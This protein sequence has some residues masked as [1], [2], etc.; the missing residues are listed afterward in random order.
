MGIAWR[1]G[2]DVEAGRRGDDGGVMDEWNF[3]GRGDAKKV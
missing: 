1:W 3:G 2:D